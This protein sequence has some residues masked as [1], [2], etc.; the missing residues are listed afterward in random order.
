M[1]TF[2]NDK[3]IA[4]NYAAGSFLGCIDKDTAELISRANIHFDVIYHVEMAS[5]AVEKNPPAP[6][7]RGI[8]D[9]KIPRPRG[10]RGI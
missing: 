8:L 2:K 4:V 6:G 7:P 9:E 10:P 5:P 1:D 3:C